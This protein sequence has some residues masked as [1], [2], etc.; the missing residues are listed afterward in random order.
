MD[1]ENK[2]ALC[3]KCSGPADGYKCDKCGATANAH[4]PNHSDPAIGCT[5][6]NCVA[7]CTSCTEAETNCTCKS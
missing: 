2:T 1:E 5:G 6:E 7:K 3:K 4:D